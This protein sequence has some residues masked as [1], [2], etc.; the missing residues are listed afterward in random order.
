MSALAKAKEVFADSE[1]SKEEVEDAE[2]VLA[3]AI[4]ELK[5]VDK[6]DDKD[7]DKEVPN[8]DKLGELIQSAKQIDVKLYTEE[9]AEKFMSA[10]AKAKEVFADEDATKAEVEDAEQALAKAIDELKLKEVGKEDKEKN[11]GA[12]KTGDSSTPILFAVIAVLSA[13][14]IFFVRKKEEKKFTC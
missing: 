4:D 9:S 10:L 12:V 8:K 2:Q 5:E 11:A 14:T 7:E 6:D 13:G 3:K 1:A